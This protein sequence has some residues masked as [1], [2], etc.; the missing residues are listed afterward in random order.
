MSDGS[1]VQVQGL[2]VGGAWCDTSASDWLK[3][4][5]G[6]EEEERRA[7][8]VGMMWEQTVRNIWG[9]GTSAAE[10]DAINRRGLLRG[11]GV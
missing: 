9:S 10:D 7:Q 1:K 2:R 8:G 5:R 11:G 6:E 4:A 3:E